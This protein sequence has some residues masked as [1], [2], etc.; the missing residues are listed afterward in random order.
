MLGGLESYKG[1]GGAARLKRVCTRRC[2]SC[3][4]VGGQRSGEHV[5]VHRDFTQMGG[6]G[7][8]HGRARRTRG[9]PEEHVEGEEDLQRREEALARVGDEVLHDPRKEVR[10]RVFH[11]RVPDVGGRDGDE[12]EAGEPPERR[13]AREGEEEGGV[14]AGDAP[15]EQVLL[16]AV[17]ELADEGGHEEGEV[18]EEGGAPDRHP[19]PVL[20]A[21]VVEEE[22]HQALPD[23]A[24][25]AQVAHEGERVLKALLLEELD[26]LLPRVAGQVPHANGEGDREGQGHDLGQDG[27]QAADLLGVLLPGDPRV[28]AVQELQVGGS[29]EIGEPQWVSGTDAV[30]LA[31]IGI[32]CP[33]PKTSPGG[34][35]A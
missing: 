26:G 12:D 30:L 16:P 10:L 6:S 18:G 28:F 9:A 20:L 19:G 21:H 29:I 22:G 31:P 35:G 15:Q 32:P 5:D 2:G 25:P 7:G 14:V 8:V 17:V 13:L 23:A 27:A 34:R 1:W 3:D 33:C 24:D 4:R 11:R